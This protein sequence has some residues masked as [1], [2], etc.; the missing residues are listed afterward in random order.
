MVVTPR[1]HSLFVRYRRSFKSRWLMSAGIHLPSAHLNLMRCGLS[2]RELAAFRSSCST[3]NS[4]SRKIKPSNDSRS[5][6]KACHKQ[7]R[8]IS[9]FIKVYSGDGYSTWQERP[10]FSVTAVYYSAIK[11]TSMNTRGNVVTAYPRPSAPPFR[12]GFRSAE[13]PVI[14]KATEA[15]LIPSLTKSDRK[16]CTRNRDGARPTAAAIRP[17]EAWMR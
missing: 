1:G 7:T 17:M 5:T 8:E 4:Q 6:A 9:S 14:Q 13:K 10:P 15:N 11:K 3:H 2:N 16:I 12:F